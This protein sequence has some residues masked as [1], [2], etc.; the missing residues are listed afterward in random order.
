M[1]KLLYKHGAVVH[2]TVVGE[3][4]L[5]SQNGPFGVGSPCKYESVPQG[6]MMNVRKGKRTL[7]FGLTS[8]NPAKRQTPERGQ[9]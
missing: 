6:P 2:D 9:Y 4:Q 5:G 1:F 3:Q 8:V 7:I